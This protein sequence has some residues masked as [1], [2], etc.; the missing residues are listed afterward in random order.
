MNAGTWVEVVRSSGRVGK[1]ALAGGVGKQALAGGVGK[2]AC[3]VAQNTV[4][5]S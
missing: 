3:I 5:Y 4:S 1:E 2:E